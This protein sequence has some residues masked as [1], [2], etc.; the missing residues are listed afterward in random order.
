M[1]VFFQNLLARLQRRKALWLR[2]QGWW[3]RPQQSLLQLRSLVRRLP[4]RW[5]AVLTTCVYG[6][7]A[8]AWFFAISSGWEHRV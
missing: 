2:L 8:G 4:A 3:P 6:L 7:G 1:N 5:R